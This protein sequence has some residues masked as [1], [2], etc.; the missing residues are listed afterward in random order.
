MCYLLYHQTT[1]IIGF[2]QVVCSLRKIGKI[3]RLGLKL[4]YRCRGWREECCS[5]EEKSESNYYNLKLFS[6]PI[7]KG[8]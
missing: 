8:I 1:D 6:Y 2:A 4:S 7:D 3:G 5:F